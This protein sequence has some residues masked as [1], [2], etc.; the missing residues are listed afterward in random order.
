MVMTPCTPDSESE[1][2]S[3]MDT[4]HNKKNTNDAWLGNTSTTNIAMNKTPLPV[5]TLHA[6]TLA[7]GI[8]GD[9]DHHHETKSQSSMHPDRQKRIHKE[10]RRSPERRERD[11]DRDHRSYR[12][13]NRRH[14]SYQSSRDSRPYF[15]R[16]RHSHRHRHRRDRRSR[17]KSRTRSSTSNSPSRSRSRSRHTRHITP[18]PPRPQRK[19]KA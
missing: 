9:R 16:P 5:V 15:S 2:D 8:S 19:E 10:K 14:R 6:P 17:S 11:R 3:P 12:R 18:P 13:D 7:Y 4:N 1:S